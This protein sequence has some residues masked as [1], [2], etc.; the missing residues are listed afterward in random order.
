MTKI[1]C[2]YCAKEFL[3]L[4]DA[5]E[6]ECQFCNHM[7]KVPKANADRAK[8]VALSQTK[9]DSRSTLVTSTTLEDI[10]KSR[11]ERSSAAAIEDKIEDRMMMKDP[12]GGKKK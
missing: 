8:R 3:A 11:L 5:T 4:A 6:A 10:I 9:L 12:K 2:V 7:Q 1:T